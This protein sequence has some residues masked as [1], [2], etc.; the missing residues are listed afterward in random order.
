MRRKDLKPGTIFKYAKS[1]SI[2]WCG[3]VDTLHPLT[4]A[5]FLYNTE[6]SIPSY[7][8]LDREVVVLW[9]PPVINTKSESVPEELGET[10]L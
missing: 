4:P 3:Y 1:S 9:S 6:K 8:D 10:S 7:S 5:G 2:G